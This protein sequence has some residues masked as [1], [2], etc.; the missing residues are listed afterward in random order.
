MI[1]DMEALPLM[2]EWKAARLVE[3]TAVENLLSAMKGG[4]RENA[5]LLELTKRMEDTHNAAMDIYDR[6]QAFRLDQV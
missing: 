1:Y 3:N 5:I 6:L 2:E 4:V